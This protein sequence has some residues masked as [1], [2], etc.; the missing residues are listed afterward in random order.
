[1]YSLSILKFCSYL[2]DNNIKAFSYQA[3]GGAEGNVAAGEIKTLKS[4]VAGLA[5]ASNPVAADGGADTATLDEMLEIGPAMISHRNRAVTA[6]DFEWLAKEASRKVVKVRCLPNINNGMKTEVGCVTVIIVP[7][8]LEDKPFPSL[9]L[10]RKVRRYLEAHS[11]NTLTSADHIYLEGP[12]YIEI[13][14]SVDIFV[15]SID[16][17]YEVEREVRSKLNAFFHPLTGGPERKGWDF[18]RNVS[19]SDIYALLEDIEG[20]DHVANL[21]LTSDGTTNKDVVEIK[22]DFLVANGTHEINLQLANGG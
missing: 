8:L 17:A 3:G 16:V 9:E 2:R 15:S 12:S 21:R 1:L 10:R 6:E 11:A 22:D 5:K 7:D 4:A 13:S 20:V 19:A 18:G 14:V